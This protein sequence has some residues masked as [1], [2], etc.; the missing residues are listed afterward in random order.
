MLID[1][2]VGQNQLIS[3]VRWPWLIVSSL[4][5]QSLELLYEA[6]GSPIRHIYAHRSLKMHHV[7]RKTP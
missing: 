4:V 1:E 2:L 3:R 7:Q 5:S 6:A